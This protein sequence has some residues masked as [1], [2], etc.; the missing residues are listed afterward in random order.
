MKIAITG[1]TKGVGKALKEFFEQHGH[2]VVGFSRSTGYNISLHKDRQTILQEVKDFDVFINNAYSPAGQTAMLSG[3]ID[4]W[5][6]TSN[7]IIN[8]NSKATLMEIPPPFMQEYVKDKLEQTNII[9]SRFF[10]GSPHIINV[11]LGLVDTDMAKVF[12]AKKLT[13]L[14]VAA[15]IY[16][17]VSIREVVAV[18]DILIEVPDLDWNNI[19]Q[20]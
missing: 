17:L 6:N 18:Q 16:H 7:T 10:K 15:L 1:H 3:I 12:D 19:K 4:L 20:V 13:T 2:Y 9:A 14:D 5:T 8:I 11:T